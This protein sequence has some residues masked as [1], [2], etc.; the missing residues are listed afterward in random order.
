MYMRA[1]TRKYALMVT[2]IERLHETMTFMRSY[3]M[4]GEV[5]YTIESHYN[6]TRELGMHEKRMI[7]C[8]SLL[9]VENK[10]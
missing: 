6:V 4:T 3:Y 7:R 10:S 1:T 8:T 2:S 9:M 5:M